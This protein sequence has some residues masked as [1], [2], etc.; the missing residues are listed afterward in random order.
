MIIS[1]DNGIC[2]WIASKQR[3]A[4]LAYKPLA[5]S[6]LLTLFFC[7]CTLTGEAFYGGHADECQSIL[8]PKPQRSSGGRTC[9]RASLWVH[10]RRDLTFGGGH[11]PRLVS[12]TSLCP[13]ACQLSL[14][15]CVCVFMW[16]HD[17]FSYQF[18]GDYMD[19]F[20]SYFSPWIFYHRKAATHSW[21]MR[22]GRRVLWQSSM[23]IFIRRNASLGS[24][25]R[26][27]AEMD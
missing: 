18:M 3:S 16:G 24:E 5:H 13:W 9:V 20:P 6:V 8:A 23:Y 11:E 27:W 21:A 14:Y 10:K 26:T 25:G 4:G 17:G 7:C 2:Q 15:A 22:E 19:S 12:F 1:G